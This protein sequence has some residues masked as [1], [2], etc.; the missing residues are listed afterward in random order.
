MAIGPVVGA[1]VGP[2]IAGGESMDA[3]AV[4]GAEAQR[5]A[6]SPPQMRRSCMQR[7]RRPARC[8]DRREG[9]STD[10]GTT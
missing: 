10:G 5:R 1:L 8:R 7:R 3:G 6:V 4:L 9:H 2:G